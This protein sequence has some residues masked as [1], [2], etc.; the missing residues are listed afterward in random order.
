[1]KMI[2]YNYGMISALELIGIFPVVRSVTGATVVMHPCNR[3]GSF[4]E[5]K[6]FDEI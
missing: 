3:D 4:M 5:D 6:F 1:M 2:T